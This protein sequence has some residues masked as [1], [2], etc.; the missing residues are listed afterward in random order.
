M[1]QAYVVTYDVCDD[2]R[3][4]KVYRVMKGYGEHIQL[5][6]FRCELDPRELIELRTRLS[7]EIHHIE[8][9]VLF[10][11]MGPAEGRG[12]DSITS[13]GRAWVP[14]DRRPIVV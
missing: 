8:D 1:R 14:P 3:L 11:D 10:I 4:R 2:K 9:Q 13:V 5:S 7:R 12:M 6:V